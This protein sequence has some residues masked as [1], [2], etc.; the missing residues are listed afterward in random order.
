MI[1]P[2]LQNIDSS[3]DEDEFTIAY[4]FVVD[5]RYLYWFVEMFCDRVRNLDKVHRF[6]LFLQNIDRL[7]FQSRMIQY[8]LFFESD[9]F[10]FSLYDIE[11][12]IDNR[13]DEYSLD[14]S[15][16]WE[17]PDLNI[18]V[19]YCILDNVA[20]FLQ[21]LHRFTMNRIDKFFIDFWEVK[22]GTSPELWFT[23]LKIEIRLQEDIDDVHSEC[24]TEVHL[25]QYRVHETITSHESPME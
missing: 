21:Y 25:F 16:K 3:T 24:T 5:R 11:E 8:L 2:I 15:K 17:N 13:I 23:L 22:V 18:F 19:E 4:Q 20:F 7:I 9:E 10:L 12:Y 6:F 14:F 1:S